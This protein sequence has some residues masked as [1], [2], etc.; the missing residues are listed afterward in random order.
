[1]QRLKAKGKQKATTPN[2]SRPGTPAND[3]DLAYQR[4][5]DGFI[6]SLKIVKAATEATSFLG[7]LKAVCEISIQFLEATRAVNEN[8]KGF[9]VLRES[10]SVHIRILDEGYTQFEGARRDQMPDALKDF[11][12]A[13]K[14][15]VTT[16]KSILSRMD[17]LRQDRAHGVKGLL[18]KIADAKVE[19]GII[20]DY[21]Q[22]IMQ[23]TRVFEDIT[24]LCQIQLEAEVWKMARLGPEKP[25]PMGTQHKTCLQGTR[26]PIL[27]EIR[28]WR[29]NPNVEKRIF[30]LCDIGGSGKSTVALTLCKE[31]DSIQE[32]V[33]GRFFFSKNARQTSETDDFCSIVAEDIGAQD[34]FILE[35]IKSRKAEDPHLFIRGIRHQFTKLIEEPLRLANTTIVLVIDAVDECNKEMRRE[36]LNLLV[37]KV[38]SMAN[39]KLLITS[40]P[41]TDIIAI[42]Q[43]KAIVR[44]MHFKMHGK[45][46]QSNLDDIT[47]YVNRHLF[48]LLTMSQRQQLVQRSNGLFIWITTA[49]L[50]LQQA[51]GP[52]AVRA[53][54]ESL[55]NRGEGG[56]INQV[57]AGIIRR[58]QREKSYGII[59]KVMGIILGLFE[60]VSTEALAK[61][62]DIAHSQ[63]Q[64]I[65]ASIQSVF[66]IDKVVEFLH[67]TFREYLVS[68]HNL[69]RP[70]DS[71]TLQSDLAI[72]ILGVFQE[73]LKEDI[74]G[75]CQPDEPYPD[76]AHVLD[77]D[78]RLEQVWRA[79]P[80]LSYSV[81][82]WGYHTGPFITEECVIKVLHTFLVTRVLYLIELLS[83]MGQI[84]LIQNFEEV[85]QH[86]ENQGLGAFEAEVSSPNVLHTN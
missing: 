69:D 14:D 11:D 75:I 29:L 77:L 5:R 53:T 74:C 81:R 19:T 37:E 66:R 33:V 21:K 18:R 84:H 54:L 2:T 57:Y 30:W 15:Y 65:L 55:L 25:R 44:G 12:D 73:D 16:L 82:Y 56:D 60:P 58:L 63:L 46:D 61:I 23:A 62:T 71:A 59:H 31:W 49:H 9:T 50:E 26:V 3:T 67:P 83:L 68:S 39:L 48:R 34:G 85:R 17:E 78:G 45:E 6:E 52:D 43:G 86:L 47:A 41:E 36:L 10:V 79:S 24:K 32:I 72:S 8:T 27:T 28:E 35:Q 42:L 51:Q 40:R 4:T 38:S 76:N 64:L 22:E 80:A 7:P 1:M 13:F 70:F 20:T